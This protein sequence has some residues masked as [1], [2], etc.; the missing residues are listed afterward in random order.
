[1]LD[2]AG[3]AG[4]SMVV[5]TVDNA[6]SARQMVEAVRKKRPALPIMVRARDAEHGREL[7]A[8]GATYVIP[9]AI[10]AALQLSGRVLEE[11]GYA[12][13]TVRDL[14][15]AERDEAYRAGTRETS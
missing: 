13:E 11:F 15:A 2:A 10:E 3:L 6:A 5:V 7:E 14:L 9:D 1:M 4:A 12:N 8:A